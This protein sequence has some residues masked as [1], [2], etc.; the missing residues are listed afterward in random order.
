MT[1]Q[2]PLERI[3][4]EARAAAQRYADIN[5]ACPY[6]WLTDAAHAF[7][8]AFREAREAIVTLS[9][10]ALAHGHELQLCQCGAEHTVYELE[11]R[12]CEDCG[13]ELAP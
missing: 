3:R 11:A 7:R 9:E 4:A 8:A 2:I 13:K 5:D 1:D 6:P 10:E 12:R